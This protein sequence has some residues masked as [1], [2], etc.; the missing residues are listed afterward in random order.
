[1][2]TENAYDAVLSIGPAGERQVPFATIVQANRALERFGFG[3]TLGA[4]HIK[5]LV[6]SAGSISYTPYDVELY[7]QTQQKILRSLEKS[8]WVKGFRET[9]PLGLVSLAQQRGVA[10]V[11]NCTKRTDP[12]LF[13]LSSKECSRKFALEQSS[14]DGCLLGCQRQ[15]MRAGGKDT[16][17]PDAQE[18]MALGS[19]VGNF[20]PVLVMQWRS[21]CIELGLHPVS[22]GMS[23]G[24]HL[25]AD[26]FGDTTVIG[27]FIEQIGKGEH[28][29]S[30]DCTIDNRPMTPIDPRGAWGQALLQGLGEDVP[31]VPEI[32]FSWLDPTTVKAKA[33][34]VLLHQQYLAI[35]RSVG[36]CDTLLT[37]L[38]FGGKKR[39]LLHILSRFPQVARHLISFESIAH[40]VSSYTGL[41]ITSKQLLHAAR[42][43]VHM[44]H[45]LSGNAKKLSPL[46]QRF[47]VDGESNCKQSAVVPWRILVDRYQFI[48]ALDEAQLEK[49]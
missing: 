30:N 3:A 49:G 5:A 9:G 20:D 16:I 19:Q 10:A 24:S 44:K 31:L 34:W 13:H 14:C 21:R 46:P 8:S 45:I 23:I 15:V 43:T 47:L 22:T 35:L 7:T 39:L 25:A 48:Y 1:M 12:R 40:L 28:T 33:E 27:S 26:Q 18:M 38:F 32:I 4:K 41:S 11:E 42:R 37:P 6:F 36:L 2:L 29:S 17:L